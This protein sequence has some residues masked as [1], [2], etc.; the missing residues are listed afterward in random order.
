MEIPPDIFIRYY[1]SLVSIGTDFAKPPAMER[2]CI[3]FWGKTNTG[4]SRRAWEEG[5]LESFPKDPRTKWWSG[6]R[7]QRHVIID[8]FRGA[9]DISHL[10]RWTDRY[11]VNVEIKGGSKPLLAET[12]WITSNIHPK[13]WYPELDEETFRALTRRLKIVHFDTL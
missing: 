9:V 13:E 10:L 4:K 3:V 1:R 11:P 6:Y 8:E 12:I 2:K 5:G 7:G